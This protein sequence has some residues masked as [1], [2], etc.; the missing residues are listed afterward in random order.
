[1]QKYAL[2]RN[3]AYEFIACFALVEIR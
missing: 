2:S 3:S 1:V